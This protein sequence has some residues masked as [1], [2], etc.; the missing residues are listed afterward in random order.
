MEI[1]IPK[2]TEASRVKILFIAKGDFPDLQCDAIFHGARSMFGNDFVDVNR[3]WYMYKKDRNLYWNT[4]IPSN[5][6]EY[7]RGFHLSGT[8]PDDAGVDRSDILAKI[9]NRYFD[10]VIYGS[11]TRCVDYLN[12][13][14][15]NY[16]RNQI[17]FMDGEDDQ[18]I[19]T[20]FLD[21]GHMFKRELTVAPTAILHPTQFG[22]PKE[23]M[24]QKIP[25]KTRE[26]G[27]VIPGDMSTYI[28]D[29]EVD[30]YR[31]YQISYFG[32]TTK[33]G[34]WDCGRHYE[35][36]INGC[37]PYFPD[38][39]GCP[40]HTMT[41]F[42]KDIITEV[43]DLLQSPSPEISDDWYF[44][45]ANKLLTYTKNELTTEHVVSNVL[46]YVT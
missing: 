46:S 8:M 21:M 28:F 27:T 6:R 38:I 37:V 3:A 24:V 30:Y 18:Q 2:G 17:L 1:I 26:Y 32:L 10:Y 14:W 15:T 9:K 16:P 39:R 22:T 40:V 45:I 25:E 11:I 33:K 12:E 34:G 13:V 42:P 20:Q 35:I 7:G 36:L 44:D 29:N 5:G 43:S 19:R 4:R 41:K 23:K 31:D